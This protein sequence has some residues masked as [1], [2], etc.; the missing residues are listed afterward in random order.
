MDW[1]RYLPNPA[2]KRREL[3]S[4]WRRVVNMTAGELKRFLGRYGKEAGLSRSEAASEGVRS[5][6]DSAAALLRMLPSGGA[7]YAAAEKSWSASDW[8]WAKRQ[9]AFISRMRGVQGPLY[10]DGKPTRKLL[11]LKLWGHDPKK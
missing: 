4:R 1:G 11:A 10:K 9:A 3:W 7:S 8:A 6:R 5:G 2:D